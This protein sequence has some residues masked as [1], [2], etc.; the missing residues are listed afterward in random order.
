MSSDL[1]RAYQTAE[2]IGQN[3]SVKPEAYFD[4]REFNNGEAA[5][6]TKKDA[7]KIFT[8][9]TDPTLD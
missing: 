9:P 8:A 4:L 6:K 1:K 5:W 7:E 3:L 2:I